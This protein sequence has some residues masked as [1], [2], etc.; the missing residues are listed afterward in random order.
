MNELLD[1]TTEDIRAELTRR[2]AA[3]RDGKCDACGRWPD[4]PRCGSKRHEDAGEQWIRR[5]KLSPPGSGDLLALSDRADGATVAINQ[6]GAVRI[7]RYADG[8]WWRTVTAETELPDPSASDRERFEW[9]IA[10]A[11]GVLGE[12]NA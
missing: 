9:A 3:N 7:H 10:W 11:E 12:A 2:E 4:E 1:F 6:H 5:W 8:A